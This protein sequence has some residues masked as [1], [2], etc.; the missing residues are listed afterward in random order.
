MRKPLIAKASLLVILIGY[1]RFP[2]VNVMKHWRKFSVPEA[3]AYVKH[4]AFTFF[5]PAFAEAMVTLRL[6]LFLKHLPLQDPRE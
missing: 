5:L 3:F 6:L 1:A 2:H 4:F